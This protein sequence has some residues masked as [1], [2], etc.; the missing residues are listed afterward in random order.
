MRS[1]CKWCVKSGVKREVQEKHF[2]SYVQCLAKLQNTAPST[3]D[4]TM[5]ALKWNDHSLGFN[6][7]VKPFSS[8]RIAGMANK[9]LQV[10]SPWR[11]ASPLTVHEVRLL[12]QYTEDETL[13]CV[14]FS[15][16]DLRKSQIFRC[17][18][19]PRNNSGQAS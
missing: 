9:L 4:T 6:L 11:P 12:P 17:Q 16:H 1:F 7:E 8:A 13:C 14:A 19:D 10:E 2:W 18:V 3:L 15:G 5:E